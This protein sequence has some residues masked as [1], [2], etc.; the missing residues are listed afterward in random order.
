M[1]S[2]S[3]PDAEATADA[4]PFRPR[5]RA[6]YLPAADALV[7]ADLHLG[8]LES[9]GV[10]APVGGDVVERVADLLAWCDPGTVV[11]AGDVLHSFSTVERSAADAIDDLR[12]LAD[13]RDLRVVAGNHDTALGERYD[14]EDATRL[15]DW[16][17]VCHGHE[18]PTESAPAYVIGHDH[19]AIDVGGRRLPCY[20][21]GE[22]AHRDAD[23]LVLPAFDRL[24]RG[25]AV[26][27]LSTGDPSSPLLADPGA[28]APIV[29]DES[30][31][32]TYVFPPLAASG[33][34][35]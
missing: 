22:A 7:L 9:A 2:P 4:L 6:A 21:Y 17:I 32:E 27:G 5:D 15:D 20:L 29:R 10:A 34:Y 16:T 18:E 28:F 3:T 26:N 19:P 1:P 30:G 8:R 11:L 14:V 12:D 25:T 35:L 33:A 13:G 24:A 23:V 31:G